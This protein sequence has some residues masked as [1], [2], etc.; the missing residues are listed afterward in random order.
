MRIVEFRQASMGGET[1]LT[2]SLRS[3]PPPPYKWAERVEKISL[4]AP[5]GFA[6][7]E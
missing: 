4:S 5:G 7:I 3:H 2:R 1:H 6:A